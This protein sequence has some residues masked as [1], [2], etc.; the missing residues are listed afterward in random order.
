MRSALLSPYSVG[1]LRGNIV[2]VRRIERYLREAGVEPMVLAADTLTTARVERL[3]DDFCPDVIHAF[4]ASHC[5]PLACHHAGRLHL[6]FLI[7]ITGSDLHDPRLRENPDTVQALRSADAVVCFHRDDADMVTGCFPSL[8]GRMEVVPQ[9][10]EPLPVVGGD[11]FGLS[12]DDFVV[13]LPAALRPVKRIESA[14]QAVETASHAMPDLRLVIAGG[15]IDEEYAAA[16][17]TL[18]RHTPSALWLGEVPHE[19]MGALYRR[20]DLVLNCSRSESMSNSL[21]EAMALGRPVLAADIAGNRSLVQHGVTGWLF[22]DEA[23]FTRLLLLIREDSRLRVACGE[24]AREYLRANFSPLREAERYKALYSQ[25][26][27]H[28]GEVTREYASR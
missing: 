15:V 6:P 11:S 21:M 9:G 28:A 7:T 23:D 14:L 18:L 12:P 5:G 19:R 26:C 22:T 25:I 13:L 20:A 8:R 2:T 24:R 27:S 3:L 16:V 4:H 17:R 1:P 10:V